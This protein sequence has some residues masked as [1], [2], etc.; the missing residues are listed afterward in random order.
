MPAIAPSPPATTTPWPA[1]RTACLALLASAAV[2]LFVAQDTDL[3]FAAGPELAGTL[4]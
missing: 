2:P 3:A 4:P 1:R